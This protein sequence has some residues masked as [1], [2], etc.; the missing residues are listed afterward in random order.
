[1]AQGNLK[2]WGALALIALASCA[3]PAR[4]PSPPPVAMAPPPAPSSRVAPPPPRGPA[5][6]CGALPLQYLVGKPRTEIPVPVYPNRR[7]VVCSTCFMTQD[8]LEYRQT[9]I[10]DVDT[11]LVKSVRCG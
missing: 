3:A 7:R 9:I 11:G 8:Y 5:D 10:Y 6:A 4:S 2:R 1:M